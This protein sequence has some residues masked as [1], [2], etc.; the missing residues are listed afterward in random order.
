MEL[1]T[2]FGTPYD[3]NSLDNGSQHFTTLSE[4]LKS[5]L[6]DA[7][8]VGSASEAYAGLGTA[9]Q[10]AAASMAELDTQLAALVKDQGEWV[11]RMR[12]GFGITK[13]I[14]VACLLIEML[15]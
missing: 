13:D 7:S 5:A 10:N 2:G 14:L 15:M 9:L 6:P 1:T 12:L 8:W 3:G 11:T 4:Q